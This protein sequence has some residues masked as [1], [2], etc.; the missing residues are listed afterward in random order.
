MS[1][2]QQS[3]V[4]RFDSLR[5]R[6]DFPILRTRARGEPLVFLDSAASAQKPSRVIDAM[7]SFYETQYANIHRGVYELSERATEAF[8]S[9]RAKAAALLG[10]A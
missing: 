8:E 10:A 7:S 5:A 4:Q 3:P 9:A 6:E 1:S 2:A